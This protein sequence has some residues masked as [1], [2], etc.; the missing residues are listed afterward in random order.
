MKITK[1]FSLGYQKMIVEQDVEP[2]EIQEQ[3]EYM[4]EIGLGEVEKMYELVKGSDKFKEHKKDE[5]E[6][7]QN[8]YKKNYPKKDHNEPKQNY[9]KK[10][11]SSQSVRNQANESQAKDLADAKKQEWG[12]DFAGT[13]KQWKVLLDKDVDPDTVHNYEE[14]RAKIDELLKK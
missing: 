5:E 11:G 12:T 6:S 1:E 10:K 4:N 13:W 2:D 7:K 3:L 9:T 14:L 8:R